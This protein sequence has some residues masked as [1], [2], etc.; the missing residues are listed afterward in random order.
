MIC[1]LPDPRDVPINGQGSDKVS[2]RSEQREQGCGDQ[3]SSTD[4]RI[5]SF[6]RNAYVPPVHIA[7]KPRSQ[8]QRGLVL[9]WGRSGAENEHVFYFV[10]LSSL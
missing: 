2:T 8:Q 4:V 5:T 7:L 10:S 3:L 9:Q 1:F 6:G